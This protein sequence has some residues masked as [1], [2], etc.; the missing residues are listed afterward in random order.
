MKD[1]IDQRF[2]NSGC[3]LHRFF[4]LDEETKQALYKLKR[5]ANQEGR[6]PDIYYRSDK[7][8]IDEIILNLRRKQA[9]FYQG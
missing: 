9:F 5:S 3:Q 2:N 8:K 1:A 4:D 6:T 7:E